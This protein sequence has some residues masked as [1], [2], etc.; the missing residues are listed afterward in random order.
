MFCAP[1]SL[2]HVIAR[3]SVSPSLP[4]KGRCRATRGGGVEERLLPVRRTYPAKCDPPC[5]ICPS[6]ACFATARQG[7]GC[8]AR[9]LPWSA[10][11]S[12]SLRAP[13]LL[14]V[15]P[16]RRRSAPGP[17][18]KGANALNLGTVT[19]LVIAIVGHLRLSGRNRGI[20]WRNQFR[21]EPLRLALPWVQDEAGCFAHVS[22]LHVI[23]RQ[24]VSPSLPCKGRC[25][26]TRGGG[27]ER[28]SATCSQAMACLVNFSL[29]GQRK[30]A[31]ET[32]FRGGKIPYSSPLKTP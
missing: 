18:E 27:V 8:G 12:G 5:R 32:P 31:K 20:D 3:Q 14:F 11:G 13:H 25:R 19:G 23:A 29:I 16:K 9:K 30:V 10:T 24:S 26:A 6:R 2:L 15:L 22:L 21:A 4:C 7:R 28:G 1:L 17:E